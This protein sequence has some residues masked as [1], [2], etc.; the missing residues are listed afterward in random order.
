M[1]LFVKSRRSINIGSV[2]SYALPHAKGTM[3]SR[4]IFPSLYYKN[5]NIIIRYVYILQQSWCEHIEQD[6]HIVGVWHGHA[7]QVQSHI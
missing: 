7:S 5:I 6:V 4:T 1:L 2:F 3:F